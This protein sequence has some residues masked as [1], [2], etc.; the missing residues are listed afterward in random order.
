MLTST[1]RLVETNGAQLR[2][3]DA[4]DPGAPVVILA[5]GFPELAYSW[6][7]QIPVLAGAGY[8]VLAP[9]QR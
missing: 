6:R 5:H 1:E 3:I 4:G 7:H 2:V 9:D 8:R